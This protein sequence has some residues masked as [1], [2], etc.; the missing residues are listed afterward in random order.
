MARKRHH[1]RRRGGNTYEIDVTTFLN[2]MVVL[3]PFLLILELA[4]QFRDPLVLLDRVQGQFLDLFEE[5]HGD[6]GH[7]DAVAAHLLGRG[8]ARQVA[9]GCDEGCDI[10]Q[11]REAVAMCAIA[12]GR[13]IGLAAVEVHSRVAGGIEQRDYHPVGKDWEW[14]AGGPVRVSKAAVPQYLRNTSRAS[15]TTA[16]AIAA[17]PSAVG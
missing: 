2:L 6:L 13:Y 10:G 15:L 9:I 17:C 1:Y 5:L 12:A 16:S 8:D 3:V 4:F 7:A 14:G 11:R